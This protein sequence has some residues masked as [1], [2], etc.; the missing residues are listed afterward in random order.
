MRGLLAALALMAGLGADP[1]LAQQ[2]PDLQAMHDATLEAFQA[3]DSALAMTRADAALDT[4]RTM[5]APDAGAYAFALNNLAYLKSTVDGDH[6]AAAG[7]WHEAI[8]YLGTRDRLATDAGFTALTQLAAQEIRQGDTAAALPR[9]RQ[10]V[11][12]SRDTALHAVVTGIVAGMFLDAAAY[13]DAVLALTEMA[14]TDPSQIAATYGTLYTR[15]STLADQAEAEG[16]A[17]DLAALIEGKMVVV[18]AFLSGDDRDETLR[19]LRFQR[20]FALHTAEQHDRARQELL[21]WLTSGPLSPEELEFVGDMAETA[22]LLADGASIDTLD[23]LENARTAVTFA[24]GLKAPDNLRL[25]QAMRA[26]ATAEGYFGQQDAAARSLRDAI[27]ILERSDDGQRHLHVYYDH[28]GWTLYQSGDPE[29]ARRLFDA[30]D[31]AQTPDAVVEPAIDRAVTAG[32]RARF[33][34]ELGSPELADLWLARAHDALAEVTDTLWLAASQNVRLMNLSAMAAIDRDA[35]EIPVAG[36]IEALDRLRPL[37]PPASPDFAATLANAADTALVAGWRAPARKLLAEAVEINDTALPDIAPQSIDTRAKLAQLDLVEGRLDAAAEGFRRLTDARKSPVYR[38]QLPQARWDFEL[39]AWTLLQGSRDAARV[40][41]AFEALQWTHVTR[42]AQALGA[43]ETRMA[44]TDPN[45]AALLAQRRDLTEEQAAMLSRLSAAPT[46]DQARSLTARVHQ[47]ETDLSQ[48]ETTLNALGLETAGIGRI[49]PVPLAEVQNL[50]TPDEALVTFLLPGLAPGMVAGLEGS[51]NHV[52]AITRD[53]IEIAV[54][55]E[56]S[57]RALNDRITRFRCQVAISDPGCGAGGA[58]GL[59][60]AMF[61]EE[62]D[63]STARGNGFDDDVAHGLYADLFGPVAAV[64]AGRDHVIVVPP[65]DLLRLPF[66]ALVVTPATPGQPPAWMIRNHAISVLPSVGSLRALRRNGTDKGAAGSMVGIGDPVIG[67][68]QSVACD[69]VQLAALRAAPPLATPLS[70]EPEGA[71]ALADTAFLSALPRLPDTVCELQAIAGGFD[72]DK[73]QLVLGQE[74]TESQVKAMDQSGA[75]AA[76]DV[77]VFA[78]HGLTAGEAG[79]DSPGLVLTPP[80]QATEQDDGLLTAAE[81]A[82]MD[83]NARLVVL[84]ACNTAAGGSGDADGL[85][86]LARAFFQSGAQS[87]L[88][89]HW[90]VYSRAAVEITTGLFAERRRDPDLRHADALRAATLAILDDPGRPAFHYHP[91]YW[92][93]FTV[94]GAN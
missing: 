93:A 52:I 48:V 1:V 85:S 62:S 4:A 33:H 35:A 82:T 20:Y 44:I 92:A 13:Q 40:A 66:A 58:Q 55:P 14:Q 60:G 73:A 79:A 29:A 15:L 18:R 24:R 90:S 22:M 69:T 76:A 63:D 5:A 41:E 77:L 71:V 39:F 19:N 78:T 86:G 43:L 72:P 53:G 80:T 89:T 30:A 84:S 17:G 54:I 21:A 81:I 10:A 50:L 57:R 51:S 65:S 49:D 36:L 16:R 91:A 38:A 75:L 11:T 28:L 87:L 23:R 59:R 37:A 61:D 70:A 3:G 26:I 68:A 34:L 27:T 45:R 94:V 8:A 32:N 6:I 12:L 67:Q 83:L 9:L 2:T 47:I 56:I 46:G 25:A 88:V 42:S 31:A 64:L 74:A 7:L